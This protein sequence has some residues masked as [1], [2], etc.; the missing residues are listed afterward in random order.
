MSKFSR[1]KCRFG[2]PGAA[3][4]RLLVI[5]LPYQVDDLIDSR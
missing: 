4:L 3:F 5:F 1:R 2:V